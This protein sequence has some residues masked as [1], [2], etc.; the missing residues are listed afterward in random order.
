[1][2]MYILT[3]SILLYGMHNYIVQLIDHMYVC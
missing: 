3:G 1:M 2:D